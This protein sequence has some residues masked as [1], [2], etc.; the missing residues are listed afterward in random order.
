MLLGG[1][2]AAQEKIAADLFDLPRQ[3]PQNDLRRRA[4]M[5]RAQRAAASVGNLYRLARLCRIAV[6]DVAREDPRVTGGDAAGSL[7]VD[8]NH[9]GRH[10][11]ATHAMAC[12]RAIMVMAAASMPA[13]E[14][15]RMSRCSTWP[16]S[17][18][19]TPSISLSDISFRI[20]TVKATEACAGLRPVA[21][22]LGDSSGISQSFGMGRPMR[23]VRP[24][25]RGAMRR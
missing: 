15:I 25:T 6:G 17:C 21:K 16:S 9:T 3:K 13:T 5:G 8:A 10:A 2:Q 11:C 20:P 1:V 4:V 23:C 22:A 24:R 14:L 18:A 7:A 19:T 12:R